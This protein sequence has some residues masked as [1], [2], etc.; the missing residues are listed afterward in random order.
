MGWDPVL[1]VSGRATVTE[2]ELTVYNN[3]GAR[4]GGDTNAYTPGLNPTR[5]RIKFVAT[6]KG[7]IKQDGEV[8]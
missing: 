3:Q 2:G 5:V 4:G 1:L 6:D 7:L 8:I